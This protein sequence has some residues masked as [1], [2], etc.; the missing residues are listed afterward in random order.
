M[1]TVRQTY[2]MW[3]EALN[4]PLVAFTSLVDLQVWI[5]THPPG[6][7]NHVQLWR[8]PIG[9]FTNGRPVK[10]DWQEL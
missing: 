9:G 10:M 3:D 1:A 4:R 6:T 7:L 8:M 2:L 5:G